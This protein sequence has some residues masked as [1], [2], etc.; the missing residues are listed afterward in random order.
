MLRDD[1]SLFQG[2]AGV[3]SNGVSP[4]SFDNYPKAKSNVGQM[5]H[6]EIGGK[7]QP[8]QSVKHA[9]TMIPVQKQGGGSSNQ[10][11]VLNDSV[12]QMLNEASKTMQPVMESAD[13]EDIS[14]QLLNEIE[15]YLSEVIQKQEKVIDISETPIGN[16]GAS[17]VAEAISE[18]KGLEVINLS[19]CA[20]RDAGALAIFEN[21]KTSTVHLLDLNGN[22][23]TEKCFD[24]LISLLNSNKALVRVELKGL[25][26]KNKFSLQRIKGYIDRVLI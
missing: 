8:S 20:I 11:V 10:F 15:G 1:D 25:Q 22:H 23:L 14:E 18:C 24:G 21:L 16:F 26:V 9:M 17:F 7:K 12:D 19:K 5:F 13:K 6:E 3:A 4:L 2:N